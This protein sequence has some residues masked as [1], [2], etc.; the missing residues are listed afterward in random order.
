VLIT[1]DGTFKVVDR[2][3]LRL[4]LGEQALN[5]EVYFDSERTAKLGGLFGVQAF[6]NGSLKLDDGKVVADFKMTDIHT[7]KFVWAA[8]LRVDQRGADEQIGGADGSG[9][10]GEAPP[11][12]VLIAAG[13][14]IQGTNGTPVEARPPLRVTLNA[15]LIDQREVSNQEYLKFVTER[16][17]RAP[18]GWINNQYPAG[19]ADLPVVGV[20]WDDARDYC[21]FVG[22]RLPT[23]AEWEKAA[24]GTG[25]QTYPWSGTSFVPSYAVTRESGKKQP[26]SVFQSAKDVSPYGLLHMAGNVREWVDDVFKPYPGGAATNAAYNKERV[27][28]GSSWALGAQAAVTYFRGSSQRNLAWPDVG[29]RCAQSAG[30]E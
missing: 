14:F 28:R 9:K 10:P 5:Q 24:R 27:V 11:G 2:Q 19:A 4:I 17:H 29:F 30:G 16:K 25:G 1:K 12:M 8:I 21:R 23:E 18:V 22:K 15:Y 13:A 6:V 20:S 7:G 3:N 26:E